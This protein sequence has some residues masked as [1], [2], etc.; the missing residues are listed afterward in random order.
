MTPR[1]RVNSTHSNTS[2]PVSPTGQVLQIVVQGEFNCFLTEN[3]IKFPTKRTQAIVAYLALEGNIARDKLANLLWDTLEVEDPR[4]N[5]RQELY[6]LSKTPLAAFLRLEEDQLGLENVQVETG[7]W[8]CD[9]PKAVAL[10]GSFS[11][12]EAPHFEAWLEQRRVAFAAEYAAQLEG[13]AARL[14]GL[15]EMPGAL[16]I[17]RQWVAQDELQE[18][19]QYQLIRRYGELGQMNEA[20]RQLE[21]FTQLLEQELGLL[22]LPETLALLKR[23]QT[24]SL[25][26]QTK[27]PTDVVS[28][29]PLLSR[30]ER[31]NAASK[32][33]L[34]AACLYGEG[35]TL[36]LLSGTTALSEWQELDAL[37]RAVEARLIHPTNHQKNQ[38]YN[39][40]HD[41]VRL[42]LE[43]HLLPE[44]KKLLH[45]K[46]A[47]NLERLGHHPARIAEHLE[48][49]GLHSQ[50][51]LHRIRAA[52]HANSIFAHTEALEQYQKALSNGASGETALEIYQ[53][54][55]RIYG[56][57]GNLLEWDTTIRAMSQLAA[58]HSP[59]WQRQA[60][61]ERAYFELDAAHFPLAF[62][63]ASSL[64]EGVLEAELEP[65]ARFIV[66]V[67]A[68]RL[69]KFELSRTQLER[70][71][72]LRLRLDSDTANAHYHLAALAVQE[73]RLEQAQP[74][75][76]TALH[77]FVALGHRPGEAKA[78]LLTGVLCNMQADTAQATQ[79]LEIAL[80]LAQTL[81][82]HNVELAARQNLLQVCLSQSQWEAALEHLQAAQKLLEKQP[83]PYLAGTL[84]ASQAM[85][86][87]A[88]G[89]LADMLETCQK[90]IENADTLE[91][92]PQRVLRRLVWC[93]N[94]LDCGQSQS[95]GQILEV[96]QQ[97][98]QKHALES[99]QPL[100]TLYQALL[101][102]AKFPSSEVALETTQNLPPFAD[103]E[104]ESVRLLA[105]GRYWLNKN[106]AITCALLTQP[107]WSQSSE[108]ERLALLLRATSS[109]NT[110]TVQMSQTLLESGKV[111]P[112]ESLELRQVLIRHHPQNLELHQQQQQTLERLTQGLPFAEAAKTFWLERFGLDA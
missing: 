51:L 89:N 59:V 81:E 87:G 61:L 3:P 76:E 31:L 43:N 82:L 86:L 33:L 92:H 112:L 67:A 80:A 38:G 53:A 102:W 101:E 24:R 54:Q 52:Q 11:L 109:A 4:R 29:L 28:E 63:L 49:G 94:L 95:A 15:G 60:V 14:E 8:V 13:E 70:S 12:K 103:I 6:R 42:A 83:N 64:L 91:M 66:G 84:L 77:L 108:A 32:Q 9:P 73:Q 65:T 20:Q 18:T 36:E 44:R 34:E 111:P 25:M 96:A 90:A 37:E 40:N 17:N 99:L 27:I 56:K 19:A 78:R 2:V 62:E 104:A 57:N 16:Q 106:P 46:L 58:H 47:Q 55:T 74:S 50:A 26:V 22:P 30:L 75:I 71:L 93:K 97:V 21:R 88:K 79:Q 72:E 41:L 100:L 98:F 23:L 39:F 105:L 45:R 110:E 1:S 68:L 107:P 10:L 7:L 5:L 35:F 85:I 48:R 69:G